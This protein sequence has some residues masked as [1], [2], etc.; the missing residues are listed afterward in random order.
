M[1]DTPITL[2]ITGRDA[3]PQLPSLLAGASRSGARTVDP[4]LPPGYLVPTSTFDVGPM[5]RAAEDARTP[6]AQAAAPNEIVVLELADGSTLITSAA[7]LQ[8]ALATSRPELLG[9]EGELLLEKLREAGASSQ[10]GFGEAVGG[11]ISKVFTLIAGAEP[12]AIVKAALGS[13]KNPRELGV[14]WVGTKALMWAIES[15]LDREPGLYLWHAGGTAGADIDPAEWRKPI[16]EA[17]P[18]TGPML[19]FVHGVG[20]STLGSFGDLRSADRDLWATLGRQFTG[21]LYAFEHR[22]LSESPIENAI[23]LARALPTGADVSFVSHSRGGL[24]VDLLCLAGFEAQIDRYAYELEGTG[25]ADPAEA[26]RVLGELETAHAEQRDQLRTLG[27]LLRERRLNVRRYVRTASPANGTLLASGNFDLFLSG[28]LTLIGQV[29]YF[30]GNPLYSAFKRVVIEVAK[31]RTNAHLVPGIEAMLPDSPMA[32]LLRDA[33]VRA[34]LEMAV[35]AGDIQG[36]HLLKRLGVLLT[37]FLIFDN[38]DNDLVVNTTAMLAG[39]APQAGARVLFDRGAEVSHF[40]YFANV[41]T[42]SAV[43]DWLVAP[44]VAKLEP[45]RALPS[46]AEYAAAMAHA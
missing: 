27:A 8:A 23:Q 10:R 2:K 39:I 33:P 46:P 13:V 18:P 4:F 16:A 9:A 6:H 28:V 40:R 14:S 15:R 17:T 24:V 21:G 32:R 45:F 3:A 19:V 11:L 5:A 1:P 12:D 31:N 25:D 36:G 41:D 20:S 37:D 42:R 7:R 38:E 30:F 43:R 22:T 35:I 29:P 26:K 44:D 34:G